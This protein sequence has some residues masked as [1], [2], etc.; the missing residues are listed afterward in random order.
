LLPGLL[1]NISPHVDEVVIIDGGPDGPSTDATEEI[2]R[3]CEKVIYQNGQFATLDG[4]WDRAAQRNTALTVSTGDIVLFVSADMLFSGMERLRDTIDTESRRIVFCPTVEFWGDTKHL[5]LYGDDDNILALESSLLEPTM[6]D[7]RYNPY[8][9]ENGPLMIEDASFEDRIQAPFVVKFHLGWIRPFRQQVDKHIR[10]VK[11]HRWADVGEKLLQGTER[12]LEEWAIR[13]V[14]SYAKAPS[15]LYSGPLPAEMNGVASMTYNDGADEVL[16]DFRQKHSMSV[17]Q[18]Y[19]SP[20][21][22]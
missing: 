14:L 6:I 22:C 2:A 21:E 11:Q 15:I 20:E 19:L 9:A 8:Y 7:R 13:E 4:A 1:E 3:D 12:G 5:R 10:H 16:E 17:F 18:S